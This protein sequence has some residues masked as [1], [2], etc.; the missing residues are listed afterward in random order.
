MRISNCMQRFVINYCSSK[1]YSIFLELVS[2]ILYN[3]NIVCRTYYKSKSVINESRLLNIIERQCPGKPYAANSWPPRIT[4]NN[5]KI[6]NRRGIRFGL[7]YRWSVY[8][9]QN[10]LESKFKNRF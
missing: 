2:R 8:P 10:T 6:M 3:S 4:T 1:T 9:T 5:T 7:L